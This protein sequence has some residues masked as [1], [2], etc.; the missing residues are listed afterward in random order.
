MN[1]VKGETIIQEITADGKVRDIVTARPR[2]AED[3]KVDA[4]RNLPEFRQD[5]AEVKSLAE[6]LAE[7]KQETSEKG[8]EYSVK[9]IDEDEFDHYEKIA[10]EERQRQQLRVAEDKDALDSFGRETKRR[11][12]ESQGDLFSKLRQAQDQGKA[13][14]PT[15]AERLRG[16]VVV[17]TPEPQTQAVASSSGGLLGEY[18]SDSS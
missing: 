1:F 4:I 12:E 17:R 8:P 6:Q 13:K 10:M 11:R 14:A 15:A 7:Q 16:R 3:D 18:D 9:T 2:T 5:R